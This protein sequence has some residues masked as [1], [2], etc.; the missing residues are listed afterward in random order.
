MIVATDSIPNLD[1]LTG[2]LGRFG[3]TLKGAPAFPV[4]FQGI[5][6]HLVAQQAPLEPVNA[7]IAHI[8]RSAS[9]FGPADRERATAH[10][11]PDTTRDSARCVSRELFW[12]RRKAFITKQTKIVSLGSCFAIE[13]AKWLQNN[14]YNYLVT[15][16][17]LIPDTL[18]HASSARWGT[19]F[20][21][22]AFTQ[23][24]SWALGYD[25]PPLVCYPVGLQIRDPFREEETYTPEEVK[26]IGEL[27][28]AHLE[29]TRAA[30]LSAEVV[31]LTVGLNEVFQYLPSGHYLHRTPWGMN[32]A[33]WDARILTVDENYTFIRTGIERLRA[34]NQNVKFILSVSPVPLMRTF[35]RDVHVTTATS[36]SKA[37][38]RV[39]LENLCRDLP[40][41]HYMSSFETVMYPGQLITAWEPDERHVDTEIVDKVM[42]LFEQQF[43]S[44][45]DALN[46]SHKLINRPEQ[47]HN[48]YFLVE[49]AAYS[50]ALAQCAERGVLEP[51]ATLDLIDRV[52]YNMATDTFS[53]D[54]YM[55]ARR[56]SVRSGLV[57]N[58]FCRDYFRKCFPS[59]LPATQASAVIA[60]T[61][62]SRG[63]CVV[64]V[65]DSSRRFA[66][67]MLEHLKQCP[68]T[69]EL[70]GKV[71]DFT[72]LHAEKKSGAFRYLYAE[73]DLPVA[74]LMEL[75]EELGIMRA[76]GDYLGAP[77]LRSCSAWNSCRPSSFTASDMDRAAQSYHFDNDNPS[78]WTK[79]FVYLTDVGPHNGPHVFAPGS[80]QS[81]PTTLT[82]DGRFSDQEV[83]SIYG[84]GDVLTGPAG[85]VIVADTQGFHKGM[86]VAEGVRTIFEVE[87]TT[88]LFGAETPRHG[89][90]QQILTS[91]AGRDARLLHRYK[92]DLNQSAG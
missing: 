2:L 27:W 85:T 65:S 9:L 52:S 60:E 55:V 84:P 91:M 82:R 92:R 28:R 34:Y 18:V 15:E 44:L 54:S 67:A 69:R 89:K 19:I 11:W 75:I 80:H 21:A 10:E 47:I 33:V 50:Y 90:P 79:V 81:L 45:D 23:V 61:L 59:P 57:L 77:I 32:P 1:I 16:P 6:D 76:L 73:D 71:G 86:L 20:N 36:H 3:I 17:N 87:F 78:G 38:L 83:E 35:R 4:S 64:P 56:L 29:C 40:D 74:P 31:V 12:A 14:G 41:V 5:I 39:A 30:L 8:N 22:P 7:L 26:N 63:Y 48:P 58:A 25:Q 49:H 46:S 88:S 70:D 51:S 13:L 37:V 62:L 24:V 42:L 68:V 72:T 66:D 53:N 43:C